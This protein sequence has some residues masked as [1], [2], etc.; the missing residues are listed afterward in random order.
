MNR[1]E[2]RDFKTGK[3]VDNWKGSTD[4][5]KIKLHKYRQQLLFYKILIDNS[6]DYKDKF[7]PSC[8]FIDFVQPVNG[9]VISIELEY[10]QTEIDQLIQ[11]I[12]SVCHHIHILDFPD[13][14]G[15]PESI[16]GVREFEEYLFKEVDK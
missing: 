3:A 8:G 11:L 10:E 13:I 7:N 9:Q 4:W 5:E 1:Y 14:S 2:I 6:R 12:K 16:K 15:Y